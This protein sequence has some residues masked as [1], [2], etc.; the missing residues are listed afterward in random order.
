MSRYYRAP[1]LLLGNINYGEKVDVWALGCI[2]AEMMV[3]S[4]VFPGDNTADQF[5]RIAAILGA[6]SLQDLKAMAPHRDCNEL[7][8]PMAINAIPWQML[9]GKQNE[10]IID[11]LSHMLCWAPDERWDVRK[12]LQHRAFHGED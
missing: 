3:G 1:E 6:P 10:L 7:L 5:L 2:L 11:L 12:L 8:P 4:P 9:V